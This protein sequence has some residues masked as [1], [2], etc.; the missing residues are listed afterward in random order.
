[1]AWPVCN[2][3][4]EDMIISE[5]PI[6]H[7][8]T[9]HHLGLWLSA[10]FALV[11]ILVSF[12]LIFMHATHYLRPWEQRHIIRIL[13][14]V[15]VYAAVSFL[16]FYY[17]NH[18]VYFEVIRDCYEAFAIASFFSLLCAYIAADLHQQKAYFR[19]ITPKKWIWPMRYFQKCTGG[20]QNGWLRTPRSGLTWFNVIWVSIFQY[21]FIRVFCTIVAVVTQAFDRYCLSSL[22]P[23]FSHVWLMVIE[24]V[25][26]TIA[27][28]CLI[29]FYIQ[30]RQDI[31]QHRPLLKVLAIKLVI[32]L[33]FWQTILL[34]FLTSSGA[35]KPNNTIQTPDLKVGIPAMLL[36]IEMAFFAILHLWAFSWK[37]YTVGSKSFVSESVA[38]ETSSSHLYQGG[39][40]GLKAIFDSFNP[41]DMFK[42]TGRAAKWLWRDRKHRHK[43]P[44][45]KMSSSGKLDPT[46]VFDTD[47]QD[48]SSP[49]HSTTAYT[50]AVAGAPAHFAGRHDALG[51][52]GDNLLAHSQGM[53]VSRPGILR[54]GSDWNDGSPYNKQYHDQDDI[55]LARS[56]YHYQGSSPPARMQQSP[57]ET[58]Q[59]TPGEQEIGVAYSTPY[60]EAHRHDWAY[61]NRH[62]RDRL[63]MP[64]APS[65]SHSPTRPPQHRQPQQPIQRDNADMGGFI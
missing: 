28:Y 40:L 7:D 21:C 13:F 5:D 57:Y 1:M 14:M 47:A 53:P 43:D 37:P 27:M 64:L 24:A 20:E 8:Y 36:C 2:T 15:P 34:S 65:P 45:Y 60:P 48:T 62:S 49:N 29:Q 54:N 33:S 26:V 3:T 55:G 46:T 25:A 22:N 56:S 4:E 61:S 59:H 50:G 39:F 44:S 17:Y 58:Y 41:W 35:V 18:S 16:S 32:F 6:W 19:T 31:E 23:A 11:A 51:G 63:S 52:E 10:A 30:L 9:L 38:G 12:F 42:A